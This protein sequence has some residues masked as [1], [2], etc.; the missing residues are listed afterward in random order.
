VGSANPA[1]IGKKIDVELRRVMV[2]EG[3]WERLDYYGV[4][5][6]EENWKICN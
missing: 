4:K 2:Q 3:K 6:H 1:L 5:K